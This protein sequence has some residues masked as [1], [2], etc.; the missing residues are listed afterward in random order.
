MK[1]IKNFN[2]FSVNENYIPED[3]VTFKKLINLYKTTRSG[4]IIRKIIDIF[5]ISFMDYLVV[6]T[7]ID[8]GDL[9]SL[10]GLFRK[11]RRDDDPVL[12]TYKK[13]K[14]WIFWAESSAVQS[15]E[16][17]NFLKTYKK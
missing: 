16:I 1:T 6:T 13:I 5:D 4:G 10:K 11:M 2:D 15:D 3:I 14:D 12:Y 8:N 17:I 7:V 9:E